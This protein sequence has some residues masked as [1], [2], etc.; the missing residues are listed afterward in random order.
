M[1]AI[2][3]NGKNVKTPPNPRAREGF[4]RPAASMA[5]GDGSATAALGEALKPFQ[6]RAS[7]AEVRS[8]VS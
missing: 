1:S 5:A 4:R 3:Y 6:E 2:R 7:E 8:L